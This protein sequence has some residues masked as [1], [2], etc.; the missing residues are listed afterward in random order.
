VAKVEAA[1]ARLCSAGNE[2]TRIESGLE[3]V[4]IGL[5]DRATDNFG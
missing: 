4:F 3:D 2:R 1:L 5:M